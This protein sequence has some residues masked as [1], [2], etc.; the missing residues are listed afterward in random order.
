MAISFSP[1]PNP[2]VIE[3]CPDYSSQDPSFKVLLALDLDEFS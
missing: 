2:S 1:L 3:T